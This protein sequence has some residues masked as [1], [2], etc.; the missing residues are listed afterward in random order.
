LVDMSYDAELIEQGLCPELVWI[1]TEDGRV[2]GR[3]M[4]PIVPV[5]V[6]P[7]ARYGETEA[8]TEAFACEGHAAQILSWRSQSEA[9]RVAWER[10][11]DY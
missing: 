10:A 2:D 5:T 6:P 9:E 3:C 11:I 1:D 7:D 8:T 4:Q